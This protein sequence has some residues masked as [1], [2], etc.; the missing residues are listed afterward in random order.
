MTTLKRPALPETRRPPSV[1]RV[2]GAVRATSGI[3]DPDPVALTAVVRDVIEAERHRL[4]TA[5]ADDDGVTPATAEQL[6]GRVVQ[7]LAGFA[8][9]GVSPVINATGVIVHT[10]LGRA[11]WPDVGRGRGGVGRDGLPA[12]RARSRDRPS[13]RTGAR[14]RGPPRR[15]DRRRGRARHE[16][17]RRRRGARRVARRAWWRRHRAARRAGR[18]RRRRAHPRHRPSR[19]RAAHRGRDHEP[20]ARRGRRGGAGERSG[21]RGAPRPS[22]ELHDDR[23]RRVARP[24]RRRPRRPR[25]RRDRHRRP[26]QRRAPRHVGLRARARADARRAPGRRRR[27]RHVQRRQARRR[28]AGGVHRGSPRPDRPDPSRSARPGHAPGPGDDGGGGS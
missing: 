11:P 12:A 28:A 6:A 4:R 3:D 18:D 24:G 17:Q 10:N 7:R 19:R 14:G 8:S 27:P 22:V 20:H 1:D 23:L 26:G 21:A 25:A 15:P 13:G 9:A 2:L 5:P 16:Q